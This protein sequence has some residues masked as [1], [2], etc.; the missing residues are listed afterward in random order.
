MTTEQWTIKS[1][2]SWTQTYFTEKF[3]ENPRLSAELLMAFTLD[4]Q[5]IDLYLQYDRPL[6]KKELT[7]FKQK[8]LR[9]VK[10]E[11]IAY[12]IGSKAFWDSSFDVCSHVLIPRPDTEILIETAILYIQQ[13]TSPMRILELGVGSGAIIVSLAKLFPHHH[14]F[15]TDISFQAASVARNNSKKILKTNTIH[16]VVADWLSSLSK[17]HSFNMIVTNPPYI[18]KRE[19]ADLQP[20]IIHYEPLMALDG[21]EDGLYHIK[22]IVE[23]APNFLVPGGYLLMEIA[24]NQRS[25]IETSLSSTNLYEQVKCIKDYAGNDRLMVMRR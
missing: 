20:D 16:F 25:L 21:G 22:Q 23:Q 17:K 18:S 5:R 12:I 10:H 11:P 4:L 24:F 2:L 6:E 3:V 8:I 14:F 9:R 13:Q 15:A 19:L 1:V 7:S